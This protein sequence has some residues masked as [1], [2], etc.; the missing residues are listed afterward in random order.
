MAILLQYIH[1]ENALC[2]TSKM[3]GFL[4]CYK[5]TLPIYTKPKPK[6][7][8]LE[9]DK[10]DSKHRTIESRMTELCGKS[11]MHS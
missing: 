11:N 9:V 6:E 10:N 1:A 5:T 8:A 4:L 3:R 7:R 2:H